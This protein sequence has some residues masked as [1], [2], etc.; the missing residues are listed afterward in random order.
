[1]DPIFAFEGEILERYERNRQ[2][3]DLECIPNDIKLAIFNEYMRVQP[4]TRKELYKYFIR[5][6]AGEMIHS[7][8]DF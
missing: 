2:L 4:A 3:I 6:N 5:A 7:L 8:G 1:M